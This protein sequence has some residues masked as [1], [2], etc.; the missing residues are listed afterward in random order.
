MTNPFFGRDAGTLNALL[1]IALWE[2]VFGGG[3]ATALDLRID[4]LREAGA[5]LTPVQPAFIARKR[6]QQCRPTT[7]DYPELRAS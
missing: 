5:S 6:L 7:E 4:Q 2:G 3:P 1:H